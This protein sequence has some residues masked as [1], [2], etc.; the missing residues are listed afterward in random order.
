MALL[1]A[2]LVIVLAGA[3]A[4]AAAGWAGLALQAGRG[5]RDGARHAARVES[6]AASWLAGDSLAPAAAWSVVD[7]FEA[8]RFD[9]AG[10]AG[11]LEL[12]CRVTGPNCVPRRGF[13]RT[14]R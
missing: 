14:V 6:D 4:A 11:Q 13:L 12:V 7:S 5:W 10:G 2:L 8:V 3:V 1:L 9:L